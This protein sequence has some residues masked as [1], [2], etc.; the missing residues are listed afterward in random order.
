MVCSKVQA[1][2]IFDHKTHGTAAV[3]LTVV[4]AICKSAVV[5]AAGFIQCCFL[6]N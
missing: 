2:D 4:A 3:P 6:C 5:Y 1:L